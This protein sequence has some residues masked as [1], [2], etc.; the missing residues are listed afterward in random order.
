MNAISLSQAIHLLIRHLAL[1]Q[2]RILYY[3]TDDLHISTAYD[4]YGDSMFI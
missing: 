4:D 2:D 1:F 3:T